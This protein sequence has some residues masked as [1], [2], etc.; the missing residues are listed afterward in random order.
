MLRP[1]VGRIVGLKTQFAQRKVRKH[2]ELT[3]R[4]RLETLKHAKDDPQHI[5]PQDHLQLM[6]RYA[7]KERPHEL[8]DI[9]VMS[10]RLTASNLGS[11]HLTSFQVTNML[12]NILGSDAE[13]NTISILRDEVAQTIGSDNKWTKAHISR[14][15]KADSVARETLRC[16][17]F[18]GRAIFR[19]VM[20]DNVETDAGIKLPKGTIFSFLGQPAQ[21]DE[22][23]YNEPWKY[24]PFRFSRIREA[25]ISS[26]LMK[27]PSFVT[28]GPEHLSFGHG[29][30]ACPGRFLVDFELKMIIAY[31]LTNYDIKFPEEYGNKR[32]ANKWLMEVSMPPKGVKMLVKR[33]Q[34][35]GF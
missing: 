24:D 10:R 26:A 27:T 1:L 16:N 9:D 31:V 34:D 14:M 12:L 3:Y 15:I 4:A 13:Y 8:Y 6:L 7:Q 11:M 20:V 21:M 2:F 18:G 23:I 33:R 19:K 29:K 30:H 5:E 32:P 28:T 35:R 25:A 17:S 22:D